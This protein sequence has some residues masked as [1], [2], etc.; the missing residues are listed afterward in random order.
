MHFPVL[1]HL[2]I[3]ANWAKEYKESYWWRDGGNAIES[4]SKII[5]FPFLSCKPFEYISFPVHMEK[6]KNDEV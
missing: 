4:E 5:R 3:E 2:F 1:T 6:E